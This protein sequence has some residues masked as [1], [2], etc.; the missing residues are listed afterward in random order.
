MAQDE[1]TKLFVYM[2]GFRREMNASFALVDKQFNDMN[3]RFDQHLKL[4]EDD[5]QEL[6]ALK[7]Q[8]NHHDGWINQLADKAKT[9]LEY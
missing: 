2:Q 7:N 1:I 8:V 5:S 4:I 6:L 9:K 3:T